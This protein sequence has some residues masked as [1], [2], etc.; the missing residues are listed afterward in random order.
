V[1]LTTFL[2]GYLAGPECR[3]ALARGWLIIVR[4]AAG[5]VL[6]L[7]ALCL[8]WYWWF[9]ARFDPYFVPSYDVRIALAT[10]AMILLTID[11]VMVPA[12]LAGSL[13]GER[14]RGVLQLLLTTSASPREIVLGRL[15]G[16]L[17]QIGMIL[18]GG[19]P[20]VAL[21]GAWNGL[22]LLQLAALCLLL[23]S[24]GIG[25]GGL[26]MLASIA[27]R[28]GRD[29]LLSVYVIILV[30]YLSPLL[31]RLGLPVELVPWLV[32][33]NPYAS[34]ASLVWYAQAAPALVTSAFW[35]SIGVCGT[36]IAAWWLRRSCLSSTATTKRA[37]RSGRVPPIDD[38]RPMLWKELYIERVGTLGR[39]G[40]WLGVLL[41]LGIGGVSLAFAAVV[42]WSVFVAGD[43]SWYTSASSELGGFLKASGLWFGW[44]L[45]WA[46]GL[47]AAV[48]IASE[49]ERGTWDAVLVTSL[50][51]REIVIAKVIG[52]LHALRWL[53]GAMVL[54][55]TLGV[56]TGAVTLGAYA[57]WIIGTLT[58]GALMAAV[59]VRSSLATSTATRAMTWTIGWWL[60]WSG[61]VAILA[62]MIIFFGMMVCLAVW[63][64]LV[65]L[66]LVLPSGGPWFP[67]TA[68]VAW[69]LA[70]N[71]VIVLIT[72]AVVAETGLR[73]DRLA[74]RIAGG[75]VASKVDEWLHGH[76][77]QPV[78]IPSG[79]GVA[80]AKP[81]QPREA[82]ADMAPE[83]VT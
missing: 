48:A 49:R 73:F 61:S 26:A 70:T 78:W 71:A 75:A 76:P 66:G 5:T 79:D 9:G 34:M 10:A 25:G 60:V 12:V 3:R 11:V 27:S 44:L 74:G 37:R 23:A 35:L 69:D 64:Y 65:Q 18:L 30:F 13:A 33:F 59:G 38:A 43:L 55:W 17:S 57:E 51:P 16:K 58:A 83:S 20:I 82:I 45:Q 47:R 50:E 56:A 6:A 42:C 31:G 53:A 24:I 15:I 1:T 68:E 63:L 2:F 67:M 54:A 41:V 28:R 72:I 4:A 36:V 21:L 62:A 80:G 81:A 77:L 32:A 19:V 52:S 7:V 8:V 22:G 46:I 14:E 29:A 40:R 39:F